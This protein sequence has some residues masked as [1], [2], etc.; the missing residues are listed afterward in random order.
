MTRALDAAWQEV[1]A[2]RHEADSYT[3]LRAIMAL[4]IMAAVKEGE[5]DLGCLTRQAL[6]AITEL[7]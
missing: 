1:E 4:K 7:Y 5:H 2:C 6:Q 3:A